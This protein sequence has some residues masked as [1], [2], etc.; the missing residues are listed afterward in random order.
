MGISLQWWQI[1]KKRTQLCQD[2][3]GLSALATTSTK[4]T[5][6]SQSRKAAVTSSEKFTWPITHEKLKSKI[7]IFGTKE[8]NFK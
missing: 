8:L 3:R 1:N 5:T 2:L 6:P 7:R 4:I